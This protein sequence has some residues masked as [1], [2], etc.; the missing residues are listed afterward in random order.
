MA[1]LRWGSEDL[2]LTHGHLE[3]MFWNTGMEELTCLNKHAYTRVYGFC[4]LHGLF[5]TPT[6]LELGALPQRWNCAFILS[7]GVH[8][9]P[10]RWG[11]IT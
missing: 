11:T 9:A 10:V 4:V 7:A 3:R 5:F 6:R 1:F 2:G 8:R